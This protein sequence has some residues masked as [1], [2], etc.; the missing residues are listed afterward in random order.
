MIFDRIAR[1]WRWWRLRQAGADVRYDLQTAATFFAG[2]ARGFKC[3][4]AAYFCAGARVI[5]AVTPSGTASLDIGERLFVNH[6]AMIDCHHH[7]RIGDRVLIGPHA[8]IGDFDHDASLTGCGSVSAHGVV[9]PVVVHDDVWIGAN[10]VVL[11]GV[12]VGKGAIIAAGAVVIHNVPPLTVVAGNPAQVV[13][14]RET[15]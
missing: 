5:V 3:G 13:R 8:Y 9:A 7:I 1:R 11:K 10:A 4:Q 15:K 12:T 14:S 6:Y 2:E